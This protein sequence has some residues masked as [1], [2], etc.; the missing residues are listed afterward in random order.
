MLVVSDPVTF[1]R[2]P[3][4]H[5]RDLLD[6]AEALEVLLHLVGLGVGDGRLG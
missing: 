3:S 1:G 4:L 6:V 2:K 5:R